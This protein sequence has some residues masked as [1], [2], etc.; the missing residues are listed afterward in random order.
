MDKHNNVPYTAVL[1]RAIMPC[2]WCRCR[3][4]YEGMHI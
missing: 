4:R 2:V 1:L 3:Q